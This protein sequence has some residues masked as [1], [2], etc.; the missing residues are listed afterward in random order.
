MLKGECG[1]PTILNNIL[2][3]DIAKNGEYPYMALLMRGS[4][5]ICSGT[6][7]NKRYVLTA[8]HCIKNADAFKQKG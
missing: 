4:E 7:I 1:A 8:A 6:L 5:I 3:G 2:G